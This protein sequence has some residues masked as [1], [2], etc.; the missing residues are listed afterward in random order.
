MPRPD[1]IPANIPEPQGSLD[2][3][4]SVSQDGSQDRWNR[5]AWLFR[6]RTLHGLEILLDEAFR[7]PGTGIRFGIDEPS[8]NP[9][10]PAASICI[11]DRSSSTKGGLDNPIAC[12]R[13][14]THN[15]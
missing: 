9:L 13:C 11:P 8:R 12:P 15:G 7:I 10:P 1:P 6:D 2:A 14:T 4:L 5:G 3:G